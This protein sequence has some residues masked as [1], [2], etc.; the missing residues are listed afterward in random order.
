[1]TGS[2]DRARSIKKPDDRRVYE[3]ILDKGPVLAPDIGRAF[4]DLGPHVRTGIMQ[5]LKLSGYIECE[6]E[7]IRSSTVRR[8][9]A[10][11]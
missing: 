11:R 5:R 8:W 4:P 3:Y 10:L 9:R 6:K 7:V 1:M 2:I